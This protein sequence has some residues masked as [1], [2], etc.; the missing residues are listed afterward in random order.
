MWVCS[1]FMDY[2]RPILKIWWAAVACQ[3]LCVCTN[4]DSSGGLTLHSHDDAPAAAIV[5]MLI[6][7]NALPRSCLDQEGQAWAARSSAVLQE[8]NGCHFL[9]DMRVRLTVHPQEGTYLVPD[10]HFALE[11]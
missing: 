11:W 9:H 2:T 1:S 10:V 8:H 5:P 3:R 7:V 4:E 6:Q